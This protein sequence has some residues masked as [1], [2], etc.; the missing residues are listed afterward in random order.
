MLLPF[1]H[2][3]MVAVPCAH[4]PGSSSPPPSLLPGILQ[5]TYFVAG[6]SLAVSVLVSLIQ[7]GGGRGMTPRRMLSCLQLHVHL[8]LLLTALCPLP[9][10]SAAPATCAAWARPLM[11]SWLPSAR[12]GEWM[13]EEAMGCNAAGV[14]L[15]QLAWKSIHRLLRGC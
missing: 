9:L 15:C 4:R 5:Y 10:R 8:V 2:L 12:P 3:F 11:S 14:A 13:W 7:V 1:Q 6:I